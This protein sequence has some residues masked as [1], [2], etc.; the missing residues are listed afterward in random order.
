MAF[1]VDIRKKAGRLRGWK[2]EICG[3]K[4]SEGWAMECHHKVASSRGGAD[5]LE[6]LLITCQFCHYSLHLDMAKK[7]LCHPRSPRLIKERLDRTG[8]RTG[9]W[10]RLHK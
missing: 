9:E 5:T 8:G 7:G 1:P 2:C 10:L 3:R 6:N 4:Y